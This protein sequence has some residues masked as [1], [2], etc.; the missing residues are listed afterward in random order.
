MLVCANFVRVSQRRDPAIGSRHADTR[1][2]RHITMSGTR[3][4]IR[5]LAEVQTSLPPH[6]LSLHPATEADLSRWRCTFSG[7]VDSPYALGVFVVDIACGEGYPMRPPTMKFATPIVH[8][9]V[10]VRS[11]EI[12]LDV[13]K[14][15]WSPAWTLAAACTAVRELLVS[16]EPDSPLN[17]DAANLLRAGDMLGYESLVRLY[18]ELYARPSVAHPGATPL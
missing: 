4:L 14:Q 3:R 6:L 8:P 12:C 9:N 17:I 11:G 1:T 7:Q 16:P 15:Q 5:E 2:P 10:D 18:V 13:L